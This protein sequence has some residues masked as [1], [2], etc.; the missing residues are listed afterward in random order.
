MV[1]RVKR[2]ESES[3]NIHLTLFD[4]VTFQIILCLLLLGESYFVLVLKS[5]ALW[6][7]GTSLILTKYL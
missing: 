7:Y 6:P 4:I 3:I 5:F 1:K 2:N